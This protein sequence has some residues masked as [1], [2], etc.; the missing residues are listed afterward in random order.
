MQI[1]T[2]TLL[3]VLSPSLLDDD[4]WYFMVLYLDK[5]IEDNGL[6]KGIE[7]GMEK[8]AT[9]MEAYGRGK[10][11]KEFKVEMSA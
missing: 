2:K 1:D 8:L 4:I 11:F 7:Q 5:K 9:Y 6:E 3:D 10:G